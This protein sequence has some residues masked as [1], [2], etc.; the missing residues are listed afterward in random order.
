MC[1]QAQLRRHSPNDLDL[2]QGGVDEP[3]SSKARVYRHDQHE[4]YERQDLGQGLGGRGRVDRNTRSDAQPPDLVDVPVKVDRYLLVNGEQVGSGL[5]VRPDEHLRV[6]DHQVDV[7]ETVRYGPQRL[8]DGQP[9][10][11]VGNVV[12]VHDVNLEPLRARCFGLAHVFSKM[13]HG[14]ANPWNLR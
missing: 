5:G 11:D 6:V 8:Q 1:R 12:T 13:R 4:V 9:V 3:L 10:G 7:Q 2:P 14:T